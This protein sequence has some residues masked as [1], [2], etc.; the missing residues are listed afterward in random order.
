MSRHA[1]P[2]PRH[3][4]ISLATAASKA[5]LGLAIV[6]GAFLMI[7]RIG[8]PPGAGP[9]MDEAGAPTASETAEAPA[10]PAATLDPR[11]PAVEPSSEEP[12]GEPPGE[13]PTATPPQGEGISVQLLDGVGDQELVDAVTAVLEGMG[14]DIVAM[15]RSSRGYEETTIFYSDGFASAG[16]ALRRADDRFGVVEPNTRLSTSVNL[17]VVIGA[18]WPG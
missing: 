14:Y 15:S 8:Q 12:T 5:A 7:S 11:S 17:H 13:E 3:F 4:W 1:D 9:A 10:T 6:V 2:D 16:R 18:D